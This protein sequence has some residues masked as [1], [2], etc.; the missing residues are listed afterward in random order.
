MTSVK[1][2]MPNDPIKI[3][4]DE[5]ALKIVEQIPLPPIMA[6]LAKLDA[7]R[8]VRQKGLDTVTC[9]IA[10]ATEK[11]Y[12]KTFGKEATELVRAMSRGEY[13]GLPEEFFDEDEGQLYTIQLCPA[14]F[15]ACT[16]EKREMMRNVLIPIR[17]KLKQLDT[18]RIMMGMACTPLM[19]H[20]VLRVSIIGCPNCCLSPYFSDFGVICVYK[21]GL[22]DSGCVQCQACVKYCTEGAITLDNGTPVIDYQKCVMCGGCEK[23]CPEDLIFIEQ[24]GYKV[25]VGGTGSRHPQIAR[26]IAESTDVEGVVRILEKALEL[27]KTASK[28]DREISFGHIIKKHMP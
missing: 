1:D 7:E 12:E 24:T 18:T 10:R 15:G 20:H 9:A 3:K 13:A 21:P 19:S 17:N 22:H 25:V 28:G 26:T 14:R 8:R 23:I 6:H 11:G 2:P 5:E 4:W 27:C 16:R